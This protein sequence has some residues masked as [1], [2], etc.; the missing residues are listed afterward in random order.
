MLLFLRM[1]CFDAFNRRMI[2]CEYYFIEGKGKKKW[3]NKRGD[4]VFSNQVLLSVVL[5]FWSKLLFERKD[6]LKRYGT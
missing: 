5:L 6:R 4:S 1:R 2:E 3:R